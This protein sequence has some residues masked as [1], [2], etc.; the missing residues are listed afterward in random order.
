MGG[1]ILA[2]SA[3][4]G[5]GSRFTV[6]LKSV[7]DKSVTT[8]TRLV[9]LS[10]SPKTRS[11]LLV[12]D[13]GDSAFALARLLKMRGHEVR[14]AA[15]V[16]GAESEFAAHCFDLLICDIGL[17]DGTGYDLI[18]RLRERSGIAAIAVTGFGM[19]SD[20]DQAMAAGF[21]AHV[22]KPVDLSR[23]ESAIVDSDRRALAREIAIG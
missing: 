15:S 9:A 22:T 7:A 14:T 21:D 4:L 16:S 1:E 6:R 17:P 11:I 18:K 8:G 2:S 13:H 5:H 10:E 23:L 19:Q 20:I 3:G 12:E